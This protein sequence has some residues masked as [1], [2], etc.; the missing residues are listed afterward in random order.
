[1]PLARL[2]GLAQAITAADKGTQ[3]TVASLKGGL[4]LLGWS[5]KDA[6]TIVTTQRWGEIDLTLDTPKLLTKLAEEVF[7]GYMDTKHDDYLIGE[8]AIGEGDQARQS[9]LLQ[10]SLSA[11]D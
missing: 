6:T 8:G 1:M 9:L 3:G 5:L 11:A 4:D 10:S 7:V 2:Q